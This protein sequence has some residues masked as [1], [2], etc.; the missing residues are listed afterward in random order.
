MVHLKA[1]GQLSNVL[2]HNGMD[3][4]IPIHDKPALACPFVKGAR[5]HQ[6]G[7]SQLLSLTRI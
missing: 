7:L 2:Q 1:V 6:L 4:F 3:D 5:K